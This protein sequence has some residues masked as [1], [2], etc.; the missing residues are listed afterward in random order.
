MRAL[1]VAA[2]A[3]ALAGCWVPAE[4]GRQMESR[5][6]RLEE[7]NTLLTRQLEEQR[8]VLRDR[9]A[10][11]DAKIGEVQ[12][13]LDELNSVAHRTGADVV[14]RQDQLQ[15]ELTGLRGQLEEESHRLSALEGQL[16]DSRLDTEGRFAALRG[17]GALEQFEARKKLE[18][19]Q[20][21]GDPQAFLALARQQ[22]AAGE[23]AVARALY[24]E[25]AKKWPKDP[26]AAEAH[27]RMGEL[28]VA[29]G[30]HREAVLSFGKVAQEFP[31]S[32]RAPEA[33]LRTGEALVAL[34]LR[35]EAVGVLRELQAKYPA[36]PAARAAK[37]RLDELEG[38]KKPAAAPKKKP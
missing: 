35:E 23:K 1:A 38:K 19:L 11:V 34:N 10:K 26:A 2:L 13:K 20:R 18:L 6:Q 31:R 4:R 15:Q 32:E 25:L 29:D 16:K 7:E 12:K 24:E 22:E 17:S 21:P 5:I 36:S 8:D 9:V 30:R 33:M 3:L 37:A 14:A 28:A 27:F